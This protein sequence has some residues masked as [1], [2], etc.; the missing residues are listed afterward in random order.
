MNRGNSPSRTAMGLVLA[1]LLSHA[2]KDSSGPF[3]RTGALVVSA[4]ATGRGI[5]DS[6]GT[7]TVDDTAPRLLFFNRTVTYEALAA[8]TH[9][10]A[11]NGL[12]ALNCTMTDSNTV[13]V[14]VEPAATA[15]AA[16]STECFG[17]GSI[18]VATRTT[19]VDLDA[20]G[21]GVSI[22]NDSLG[23]W[24][25]FLP[26]SGSTTLTNAREG[27]YS[28][29]LSGMAPNCT[30]TSLNPT[31]VTVVNGQ[32]ARLALAVSCVAFGAIQVTATTTGLD[33]DHDGYT[34]AAD[35]AIGGGI[36]VP[37]N[38]SATFTQVG[39]GTQNVTLT[40]LAGNCS[41]V[42]TNPVSVTVASAATTQ[43]QFSITCAPV[44][45]V[46]SAIAFTSLRDRNAEI[47]V[48][49]A[50]E[51]FT[52]I[53]LTNNAA[54][55]SAPAWSHDGL[56]IAFATARDLDDEIYK[57]NADGSAP[58]N[59]TRRTG[60]DQQPAWSPDGGKVA[61][62][63]TRN[64]RGDSVPPEI[65]VM[66]PDGSGA[67]T[68][69][70]ANSGGST[71]PAWS[72]DGTKIAFVTVRDGNAEIYVMNADGS[73]PVNLTKDGAADDHPVWSPDGT[74]IAFVSDR[75]GRRTVYVMH[76]DGTGIT[77]VAPTRSDTTFAAADDYV[78]WSPDGVRLALAGPGIVLANADGSG[79][80]QL[81]FA[82]GT[83][84]CFFG[85]RGGGCSSISAATPAWSPDGTRIAYHFTSRSCRSS[86]PC[87]P[88]NP[89]SSIRIMNPDG[90]S[91]FVLTSEAGA[92]AIRPVWKP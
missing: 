63:S 40:G 23:G 68:A 44:L 89:Q 85:P 48:L 77:A 5:P 28:V 70:S 52:A 90:T 42:G 2:C 58:A 43:V 31:S 17:I 21:Y 79:T 47:Y 45:P 53:D 49:R 3:V 9:V 59:L 66:A 73:A 12:Q 74:R 61:F 56:A 20:D 38:G 37:A 39:P 30:T 86:A 32:T 26:A 16:F 19:G 25:F 1:V 15:H 7:V 14:T 91:T 82:D 80:T 65:F 8:G 11:F 84:R 29:S 57:M 92:G 76:A 54:V 35:L 27:T 22:T 71:S 41:V 60:A 4:P 55:D 88:V 64:D 46:G 62:M 78:S 10:V 6:G 18:E 81:V 24:N 51:S 50:G 87:T 34:A 69:L 33:L 36:A 75:G 83:R 67:R 72:P 13:T